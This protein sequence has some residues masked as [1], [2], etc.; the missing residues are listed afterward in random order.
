MG[1]LPR[2]ARITAGH[3]LLANNDLANNHQ[4]DNSDAFTDIAA[5]DPESAA[6]RQIRGGRVSIIFQEPMTSLSP[7]I[8]LATRLARPCFYTAMPAPRRA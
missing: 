4:G 6:M 1:I 7:Y 5:L 2:A 8:P 3:I